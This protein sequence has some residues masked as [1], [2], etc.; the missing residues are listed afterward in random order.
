MTLMNI[1]PL[2]CLQ[3]LTAV[4]ARILETLLD[5]SA[6]RLKKMS[7]GSANVG[8]FGVQTKWDV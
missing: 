2:L 5:R 7:I 3:I 1:E 8:Q 6:K 4:S